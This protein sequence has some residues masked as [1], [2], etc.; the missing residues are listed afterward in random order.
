MAVKYAQKVSCYRLGIYGNFLNVS[1]IQ[2]FY[3]KPTDIVPLG[4]LYGNFLTNNSSTV[5]AECSALGTLDPIKYSRTTSLEP[6]CEKDI[7]L[8]RSATAFAIAKG[9]IEAAQ[10]DRYAQAIE[11]EFS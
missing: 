7:T 2:C 11:P 4:R 9:F 3:G 10:L 6:T 1:A 5:R 8:S